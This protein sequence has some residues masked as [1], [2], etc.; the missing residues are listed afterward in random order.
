MLHAPT[1]ICGDL[2]RTWLSVHRRAGARV[3]VRIAG[4]QDDQQER[5]AQPL[6]S[7]QRFAE[8]ADRDSEQVFVAAAARAGGSP[9]AGRPWTPRLRIVLRRR[10]WRRRVSTKRQVQ[11]PDIGSE[12][13][14][15]LAV[16]A[17]RIRPFKDAARMLAGA[18]SELCLRVEPGKCK[19]DP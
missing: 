19:E 17:R 15:P 16:L 2:R 18:A 4:A 11:R 10:L 3:G 13:P 12:R 1:S 5:A 9:L 14:V 6:S 8:V 7:N